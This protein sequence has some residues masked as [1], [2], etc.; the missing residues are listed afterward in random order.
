MN[1][2]GRCRA[3]LATAAT[4]TAEVGAIVALTALGSRRAYTVPLGRLDEW[5]KV[6]APA[7]A[8]V[9]ALRWVALVGAWWLLASTLLYVAAVATRVP[10]AVRAVRWA[11]LPPVRRLVDTAFATTVIAA[12]LV[13]PATAAHA[14]TAADPPSTTVVR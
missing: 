5:L 2:L 1:A 3:V 9:A 7:D 10:G 11:A 4:L 13:G 12:T 8:L 6:T 14:T